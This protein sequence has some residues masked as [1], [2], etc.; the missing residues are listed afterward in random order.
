LRSPW[1]GG[2]GSCSTGGRSGARTMAETSHLQRTLE[3]A[4]EVLTALRAQGLDAV[5]IGAMALAVHGYPR[6]TEDFDLAIATAPRNL[7]TL[8][9]T[10][11]RR[12]FDAEVREPDAEDPLGGVVDV[13]AAGADL[14]QVINFDNPPASG[15]P[16]L[17]RGA[18]QHAVELLPGSDLRVVDPYHLVA[19]KLYAGGPKSK[20]DILELLERNPD[21]DRARLEALCAGY[22][23]SRQLG[24]VLELERDEE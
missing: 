1:A 18:L 12:G 15:F 7:H 16:R 11:R 20:L 3:V 22:G 9:E 24:R 5:V 10:L 23:L 21:L 17:V 13:R 2:A 4:S 19:F 6:D 14:V 8:A